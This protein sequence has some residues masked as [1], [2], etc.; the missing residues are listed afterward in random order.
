VADYWIGLAYFDTVGRP[1]HR[2]LW[3]ASVS[4]CPLSESLPANVFVI[5]IPQI[6]KNLRAR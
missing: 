2:Y 6:L 4:G 3:M 5:S 1:G